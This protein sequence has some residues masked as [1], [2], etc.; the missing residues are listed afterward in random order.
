MRK[1]ILAAFLFLI[2][3]AV[4]SSLSSCEISRNAAGNPLQA[5]QTISKVSNILATAKQIS[6]VLGS[7]LGLGGDQQSTLTDI[8]SNYIGNTNSIASL[9]QSNLK[10]YAKKLTSFN[11]G[12]LGK[13]KNILT[14]AQYARLL[15]LGGKNTSRESLLSGL[16]GGNTLSSDATSVLSGLLLNGI[17]G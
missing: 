1:I 14:V 8:F 10:S 9:A 5:I 11:K 6:G 13:I 15:G 16:K 4:T 3:P 12:T 17:G 7:T 2:A